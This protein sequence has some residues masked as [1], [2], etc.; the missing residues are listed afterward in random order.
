[1][2]VLIHHERYSRT[3]VAE[4]L[5]IPAG[6]VASRL[7][8]ANHLFADAVARLSEPLAVGLGTSYGLQ[9]WPELIR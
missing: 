4:R 6:T 2:F 5:G 8:R 7:R 1:M 3:Q 9:V